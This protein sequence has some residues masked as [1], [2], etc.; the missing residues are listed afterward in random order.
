MLNIGYFK[1]L[2]T[3]YIIRYS[4]GK[5]RDAGQG[6]AFFYFRY[7]TQI[8]AVPTT[9][10]DASF[11]FNEATSNFQLVTIQGQ[12]TYRVRDPRKTAELLNFSIEP[13]K[14][15]YLASD[16]ERLGTRITN[17]LQMETRAAIQGRT[18]EQ[19]LSAY[20]T[21][22]AEVF[23][24]ARSSPVLEPLGVELMAVTFIAAKPTPEVGKALEAPYREQLLRKSD[25]ATFARR[26][27]AVEEERKIKE[28][29]LN[30]EITL[31]EKRKALIDLQAENALSEAQSRG[32]AMEKEAEY[33]A[34]A[35]A[36]ELAVYRGFGPR[37]LLAMALE[38][39][40]RNA[41]KVGNLTI[42]TEVL[43]SLLNVPASGEGER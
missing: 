22:A 29:E 21:I 13:V 39:M 4:G 36:G 38:Q 15:T 19:V 12:F 33:Q 3:E 2:P 30:T 16:A 5:V 18:L 23:E 41:E 32:Q 24:R 17:A 7:N 34:R 35:R 25:E 26:A 42:T 43:S 1:G 31:E 8:V 11:V 10:N 20:E 6:L 37:A 14:R 27:A 28:N 9:S 40:G